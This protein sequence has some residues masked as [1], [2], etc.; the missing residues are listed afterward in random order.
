MQRSSVRRYLV[1]LAGLLLTFALALELY[2]RLPSRA[3]ATGLNL[4][5]D[6]TYL[7]LLLHGSD[8]RDEPTLLE[9]TE[10][11]R[12]ELGSKPGTAVLHYVWSPWSDD[13]LRAGIHGEKIGRVLGEELA[14]LEMLEHIRLIGHSAGAYPLDPLCETYRA[15]T[16]TPARIEMTYLDGMA[17]R[18]AWDYTYGYRH[19]GAC[20]DFAAA[21]Y[22]SDDFAPGTNAPLAQGY[23]VDVTAAP[24]RAA[25]PGRGH[26]WP[27][28]YFLDILDHDEMTPGLRL[29]DRLP[30]GNKVSD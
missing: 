18:G 26:L 4:P 19:Y 16:A 27:V 2:A 30:R 20:A 7:V 22:S 29:H 8:G 25:Y 10:R 14:G 3:V 5:A 9:V 15:N 24:A 13:R 6:T 11:F 1:W 28:Q 17:I 12:Q 21:I 23:N